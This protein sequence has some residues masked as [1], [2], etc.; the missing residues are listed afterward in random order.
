MRDLEIC[1]ANFFILYGNNVM[2]NEHNVVVV[3][4]GDVLLV[5][6]EELGAYKGR[7]LDY[8]Y[9]LHNFKRL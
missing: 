6:D 9:V 4:G 5:S 1:F 8:G 2:K 7:M 3:V